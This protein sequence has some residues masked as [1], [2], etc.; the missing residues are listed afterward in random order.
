MDSA[1][2]A[3]LDHQQIVIGQF[4]F[5]TPLP[6]GGSADVWLGV[7][8]NGAQ[9]VLKLLRPES[10][11]GDDDMMREASIMASLSHPCI[12][13][14]IDVGYR[15][16]DGAGEA[17]P[18]IIMDY[19]AG[20]T[21]STRKLGD[22]ELERVA[23]GALAAL[24][25]AH[26]RGV[27]HRDLSGTNLIVGD[28]GRDA[29]VRGDESAPVRI[30]DWG[31]S[32]R[33]E[34]LRRD[35]PA[36][37]TPSVLPQE[38][39]SGS[40][41][42]ED[43]ASD[44][45]SLGATLRNAW[46]QTSGT[47]LDAWLDRLT[48]VSV[49]DRFPT[50]ARAANALI[51]ASENKRE[52]QKLAFTLLLDDTQSL[53]FSSLLGSIRKHDEPRTRALGATTQALRLRPPRTVGRGE[54]LG[55]LRDAASGIDR[56]ATV[57][58]TKE[59]HL[60]CG[61]PGFGTTRVLDEVYQH[62]H[63]QRARDVVVWRVTAKADAGYLSWQLLHAVFCAGEDGL[64]GEATLHARI[65]RVP[66]VSETHVEQ[67]R[68]LLATSPLEHCADVVSD[69]CAAIISA[70]TRHHALAIFVDRCDDVDDLHNDLSKLCSRVN[71]LEPSHS[72]RVFAVCRREL[73][74]QFK[75]TRDSHTFN[76]IHLDRLD[77]SD[78]KEMASEMLV[79]AEPNL[80]SSLAKW[81]GGHPA[82]LSLLAKAVIR[83]E[84][85]HE[86]LTDACVTS[87][88][89]GS[90]AS[91]A[92]VIMTPEGYDPTHRHRTTMAAKAIADSLSSVL[93]GRA[94]QDQD[95]WLSWCRVA[96]LNA[97]AEDF[98]QAAATLEA[99]TR[100]AY[101]R[102]TGSKALLTVDRLEALLRKTELLIGAA[103]R[104]RVPCV[105]NAAN[106]TASERN[107]LMDTRWY[108]MQVLVGNVL[109]MLRQYD[110]ALKLAD[111][112][113]AQAEPNTRPHLGA[114][115]MR[116]QALRQHG[117][118]NEALHEL[119]RVVEGA[120]DE[121]M[122]LVVAARLA[123]GIVFCNQAD[124]STG[125]EPPSD[126]FTRAIQEFDVALQWYR[127][128]G[129][130]RDVAIVQRC[131]ALAE[132]GRE[133]FVEATRRY[134]DAIRIFEARGDINDIA[135]TLNNYAEVLRSAE[136]FEDAASAYKQAIDVL[137][138]AGIPSSHI[139]W[140]NLG[141]AHLGQQ[142]LDD[143]SD[144]FAEADTRINRTPEANGTNRALDDHRRYIDLGRLAIQVQRDRCGGRTPSR[145]NSEAI[146]DRLAEIV[147][148]STDGT[149]P[150]RDMRW[151]ISLCLPLPPDR[152][153]GK[154]ENDANT[155]RGP[156]DDDYITTEPAPSLW[157]NSPKGQP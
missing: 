91:S 108:D 13:T 92:L 5:H 31:I 131:W 145:E 146:A 93:R 133:N 58:A 52:L 84:L 119:N 67:F 128:R 97:I 10:G 19:A 77:L 140:I 34:H 155:Q 154:V 130:D 48:A 126:L 14:L 152:P 150:S 53:A 26:G 21:L 95:L 151:L 112:V 137:D 63:A 83:D 37:G 38:R 17:R 25:H 100:D 88:F 82:S 39:R 30:I 33:R 87:W 59:I 124:K 105:D 11:M 120:A 42:V 116:G 136:R 66:E 24:S 118:R 36:W 16:D 51:E 104:L 62:L 99:L 81:S 2:S 122:D 78:A 35:A 109:R 71:T 147:P 43:E 144:A 106:N 40:S 54:V 98:D 115:L 23:L 50:A 121:N 142:K 80:A 143:A 135:R 139:H 6:C 127:D 103:K 29:R 114:R 68:R 60:I 69:L 96:Y 74:P 27:L 1:L 28:T 41:V 20:A 73:A 134:E 149:T 44:L 107:A 110:L 113:L 45:F 4:R 22:L 57:R 65:A 141:I 47:Y 101:Q 18:Y 94:S 64:V 79:E 75:N 138:A 72:L 148:P 157:A 32:C 12:A 89:S 61:G 86:H 153:S 3:T 49:G 70:V 76:T 102:P 8:R 15:S 9:R 85:S 129:D 55:T 111:G 7:D 46:H 132:A 117:R 156:G 125:S 56:D 90:D 123:R